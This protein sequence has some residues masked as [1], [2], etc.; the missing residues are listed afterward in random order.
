[1]LNIT[2]TGK[3]FGTIS[4]K[5]IHIVAGALFQGTCKMDQ[6]VEKSLAENVESIDMLKNQAKKSEKAASGE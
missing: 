6:P 3:V 5:T 1:V 4:A 2:A